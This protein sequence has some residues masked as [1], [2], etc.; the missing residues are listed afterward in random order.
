MQ[1]VLDRMDRLSAALESLVKLAV[2]AKP[3]KSSY[4]AYTWTST[5][6]H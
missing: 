3:E 5:S 2:T 6:E 1:E 4:T